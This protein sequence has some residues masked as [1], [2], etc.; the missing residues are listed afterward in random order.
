MRW[1][2]IVKH[3]YG[4]RCNFSA[5]G[6]E[7]SGRGVCLRMGLILAFDTPHLGLA[8]LQNLSLFLP[9]YPY[10]LTLLTHDKDISLYLDLSVQ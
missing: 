5:G 2:P 3:G 9:V 1:T 4:S 8:F 6:L 7:G 10:A